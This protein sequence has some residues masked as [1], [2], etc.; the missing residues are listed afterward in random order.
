MPGADL[1]F[2]CHIAQVPPFTGSL[3]ADSVRQDRLGFY[4]LSSVRS[5]ACLGVKGS[6]ISE[7]GLQVP[8]SGDCVVASAEAQNRKVHVHVHIQI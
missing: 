8:S 5:E 2:G 7:I 6:S 4:F 1:A 3:G